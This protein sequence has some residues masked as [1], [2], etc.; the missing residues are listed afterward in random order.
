[1]TP[2]T[3]S[4]VPVLVPEIFK[5]EKYVKYENEITDDVKHSTLFYV[6]YIN[7]V[8]LDSLLRKTATFGRLIVLP[9]TCFRL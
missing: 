5:F 6:K 4:T 7:R 1:V 8:I 9:E 3:G 2:N